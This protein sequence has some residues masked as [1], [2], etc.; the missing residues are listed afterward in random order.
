[1]KN[2]L[3]WIIIAAVV[4]I[5]IVVGVVLLIPQNEYRDDIS[6]KELILVGNNSFSTDGGTYENDEDKILDF[7]V[8]QTVG[9]IDYKIIKA[10]NA[11]NINEIGVFHVENGN[12]TDYQKL[13]QEYVA[14]LQA[15]YRN[16]NYLPEE[17]EKI[18]CAKVKVFGNYIVYSFLNEND[19]DAFYQSIENELTK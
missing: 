19:T 8:E 17:T 13:V 9:L 6:S 11:K 3:K 10:N 16:M 14:N 1:M 2:N 18:N 12:V 15:S 4:V 5:V 7:T